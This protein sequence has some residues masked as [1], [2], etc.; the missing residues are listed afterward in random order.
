MGD[1][2]SQVHAAIKSI[3][4]DKDDEKYRQ[5]VC[6]YRGIGRWADD[7]LW[8]GIGQSSLEKIQFLWR[9]LDRSKD[10][11]RDL[12]V[13][14]WGPGGGANAYGLQGISRRYYGVDI[15]EKNLAECQ[16]LMREEGRPDYV[17]PVLLDGSPLEII[18]RVADP[19]NI[20]LSTA[21]F[22]HFPSK[23]YGFEVLKALR[24]VCTKGAA[25]FIQIRFDNGNTKYRGIDNIDEYATRHITATSY[26]LDQFWVGIQGAGFR[27]LSINALG[28]TNNYA[29]FFMTAI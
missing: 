8:R 7:T 18:D 19:V 10:S 25:G 3:W 23:E 1:D 13:L 16:R 4:N 21:V 15:S 9:L 11:L 12:V 5:D 27:P 26:Q 20:F 24:A 2:A 22:Q 28:L 6:H 29:T 14:E 17:V